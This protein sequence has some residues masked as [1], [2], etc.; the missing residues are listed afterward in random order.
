MGVRRAPGWNLTPLF[1]L[2][3]RLTDDVAPLCVLGTHESG[4]IGRRCGRRDLGT[5]GGHTLD[6][7]LIA[8]TLHKDVVH[9]RDLLGHEASWAA[10]A[11]PRRR[12]DAGIAGLRD[13]GNV[14]K[15]RRA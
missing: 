2:D 7:L 5:D 13:G 11:E 15:E 12:T 1:R 3:A 8:Y 6:H 4:E 9:A 14:G 10:E